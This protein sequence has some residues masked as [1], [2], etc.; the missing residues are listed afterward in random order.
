MEFA[1]T[2]F[3]ILLLAAFLATFWL[4]DGF[5]PPQLSAGDYRL[6]EEMNDAWSHCVMVF[7]VG[8]VS[9]TLVDHFVGT[10]DRT[11][12]RLLYILLGVI[13][14]VGSYVWLRGMRNTSPETV[15]N[16]SSLPATTYDLL[17]ISHSSVI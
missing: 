2:P 10:I 3:R 13:M 14:M 6:A 7:L 5:L 8:A 9:A 1:F 16:R 11:N 17:R 4:L 12:I 15:T